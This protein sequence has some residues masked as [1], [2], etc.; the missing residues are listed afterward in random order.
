MAISAR[1]IAPWPKISLMMKF[2]IRFILPYDLLKRLEVIQQFRFYFL[3]V[4][5]VF[6]DDDRHF[7]TVFDLLP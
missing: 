6:D 2:N 4:H 5:E 3:G 7:R 1:K